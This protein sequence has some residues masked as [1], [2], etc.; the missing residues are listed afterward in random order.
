M[1]D[2][3]ACEK[4]ERLRS[5]QRLRSIIASPGPDGPVQ[6]CRVQANSAPRGPAIADLKNRSLAE[7]TV[8]LFGSDHGLLMGEY[9]MGGKGLL[10]DLS[11]KIPCIILDYAGECK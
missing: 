10:L 8:I 1:F 7:N 5:W 6:W 2:L 9:G 4:V 11:V 3:C